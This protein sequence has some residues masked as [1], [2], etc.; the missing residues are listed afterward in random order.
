M[1]EQR[2]RKPPISVRL[3]MGAPLKFAPMTAEKLKTLVLNA[4]HSPLSTWPLSIVPAQE[5]VHAL[6]RERAYSVEDWEDAFFRSPS[7]I[8]PVPKVIALRHYANVAGEPKFCRRS[9]LLRD[10]WTC[11]YCGAQLPS[12]ELTFDH[13]IPRARGGQ[14]VWT[15]ILSA[16]IKCNAQKAASEVNWSARKGMRPF[17]PPHRPT[18]AELLRKGLKFLPQEVKET[19]RDWLYWEAE[20]AK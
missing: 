7:T 5:A 20:L 2:P 19:W 18:N 9:I 11:Q 6:C 16:C 12:E 14:T 13:V 4:D 15:N 17:K 10:E 8:I 1:A 3:R